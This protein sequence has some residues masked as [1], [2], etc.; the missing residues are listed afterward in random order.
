MSEALGELFDI[1]LP[2]RFK[3]FLSD[4]V[5]WPEVWGIAIWSVS[6]VN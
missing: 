1:F 5:N 6:L 3:S 4:D 2:L